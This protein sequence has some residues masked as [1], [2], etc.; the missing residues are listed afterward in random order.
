M[1]V[2]TGRSPSLPQHRPHGHEP[3]RKARHGKDGGLSR[4]RGIFKGDGG[5]GCAK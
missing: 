5:K 4:H 2:E 3:R 1:L